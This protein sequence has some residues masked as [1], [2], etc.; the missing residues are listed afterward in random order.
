MGTELPVFS[1]LKQS[2][3][4]PCL[5]SGSR[6]LT[7]KATEG[8][9]RQ[10]GVAMFS[11]VKLMVLFK[12]PP[13]L[14]V[15]TETKHMYSSCHSCLRQFAFVNTVPQTQR[16]STTDERERC[17]AFRKVCVQRQPMKQALF[18][19]SWLVDDSSEWVRRRFQVFVLVYSIFYGYLIRLAA[20][21]GIRQGLRVRPFI[22]F[23]SHFTVWWNE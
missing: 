23:T 13:K 18:L 8:R 22:H 15:S 3:C 11:H 6:L 10:R 19:P 12:L 16:Q 20:M 1:V 17:P 9:N 4:R 21:I 14:T 2:K 7:R 5:I